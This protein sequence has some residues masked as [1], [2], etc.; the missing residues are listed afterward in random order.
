MASSHHEGAALSLG[1]APT[2]E[3]PFKVQQTQVRAL[4]ECDQEL[5]RRAT[6]W[7]Y[8]RAFWGGLDRHI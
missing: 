3:D 2:L 1:C 7:P 8:F 4:G 5:N 6:T